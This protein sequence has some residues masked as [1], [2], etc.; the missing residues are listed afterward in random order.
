MRITL[1]GLLAVLTVGVLIPA[2]APPRSYSDGIES[3]ARS[4]DAACVEPLADAAEALAALAASSPSDRDRY[5]KDV[6]YRVRGDSLGCAHALDEERYIAW[7][8]RQG[9]GRDRSDRLP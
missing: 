1:T 6:A 4:L 5:V 3:A 9:N 8:L 2:C 7:L